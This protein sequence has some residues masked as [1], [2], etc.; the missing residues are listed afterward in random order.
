MEKTLACRN[1]KSEEPN[2]GM[3]SLCAQ[4]HSYMPS[5]AWTREAMLRVNSL[6]ILPRKLVH[7]LTGPLS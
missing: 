7:S 2:S 1:V 6:L 4:H 5:V 3:M